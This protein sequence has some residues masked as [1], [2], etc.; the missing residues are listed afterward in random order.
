MTNTRRKEDVVESVRNPWSAR[1]MIVILAF[2]AYWPT[3]HTGFMWDDH[4]MIESNPALREWSHQTLKHDFTTDVFDGHGDPYYRPMQTIFNRLDY[5][6]WGLNPIGYHLTNF[7]GHA[8]N[9]LLLAEFALALGLGSMTALLAGCL[10]AVHPIVVEQLMIIAGRA[11][12]FGLTFT[13][14]TILL[15]LREEARFW[16]LACVTYV[17]GLFFKESV[18]ITPALLLMVYAYQ[19]RPLRHFW[20]IAPLVLLS[21]PYVELRRAAVGPLLQQF[22]P[23]YFLLFYTKAFPQVLL[24][25]ARLI[26]FPWNLHSHHLMPHLTH[27]WPLLLFIF[28]ALPVELARRNARLGL[29]GFGWFVVSILPKTPIMIYGNFTLDHWAYPAAIGILL[30]MAAGF[31]RAWDDRAKPL[32]YWL[33]MVFFPLLVFWALL[34]HLNVALRGTDE[35]MYRWALHFTNSHP[36]QYNLGLL[37]LQSGR[38]KE[39][40]PYFEN[41]RA[42]YPEDDQNRRALA[43]AYD[44]TGHPKIAREVRLH[45]TPGEARSRVHPPPP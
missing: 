33:G 36:I 19:K 15:L 38:A 34:V 13:L 24:N 17:M 28:F 14:L 40:I 6:V 23:A 44:A 37:L 42:V 30:P 2:A 45:L 35:K 1:A 22:D 10:F 21:L 43:L 4:V 7:A 26:L 8:V 16:I 11:E 25:Y 5:S 31:A 12:I 18:L 29:L 41:V 9:A 39:A 32:S 27:F 20:R 3:F